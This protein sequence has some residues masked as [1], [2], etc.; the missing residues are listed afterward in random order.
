MMKMRFF[1]LP[2]IAIISILR[3]SGPVSGQVHFYKHMEGTI[4]DGIHIK[5]DLVRISDK[6]DGYYYYYFLDT[7]RQVD[8][9][10]HYGKSLPVSGSID[11]NN[12]MEFK[13]F[14]GNTEGS[15]FRGILNDGLITGEWVSAGTGKALPFELKETYPEGTIAFFVH[16]LEEEGKLLETSTS[17]AARIDLTLL[18]PKPYAN[19]APV[20]SVNAVIYREFFGMDSTTGDPATL[21]EKS[22][23]MFF[24]NYRKANADLYQEGASS[25]NWLKLKS[26]RIQYNENQILS[27]EFYDHGYT[28]GAHGLSISKFII[29]DL[30]DGHRL[31]LDEIFRPDYRNDLR[32]ILNAQV[33]KQYDIANN[34]DLRDAGFWVESFDPSENFYLN[35]DGLG[36]YYNQYEVAPFAMGP[37]DIFIPYN[38]LKRIMNTSGMVYRVFDRTQ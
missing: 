32:D 1:W 28:G 21:L 15:S 14:G 19:A 23:D 35:K 7:L 17:P 6:L 31:S 37:V 29:I 22:K 36:F 9:G 16:H 3:T 4:A 2:A 11:G 30:N 18:L 20:D 13:E 27:L 5:A 25:F 33:R 26:V 34:T 12:N 24:S 38:K 10:M 8:F